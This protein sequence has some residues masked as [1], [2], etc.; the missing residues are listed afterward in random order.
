MSQKTKLVGLGAFFLFI[1]TFVIEFISALSGID[2]I[3]DAGNYKSDLI[4]LLILAI[5]ASLVLI[6]NS[7]FGISKIIKQ[8]DRDAAFRRASDGIGGFG[9]YLAFSEIYTIILMNKI[10][11]DYGGTYKTPASLIIM[12]VLTI[13]AVILAVIGSIKK[14]QLTAAIRSILLAVAALILFVVSIITITQ[15]D[16]KALT[17][18]EYVFLMLSLLVFIVFAYF[19]Y[20]EQKGNAK[21]SQNESEENNDFEENNYQSEDWFKDNN[22]NQ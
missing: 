12:I 8:S 6:A 1:I 20:D 16:Q 19:C 11:R 21:P 5:L 10:A 7:V 17:I 9:A 18:V 4:I 3:S 15:G 2:A 22:S 14:I 13:I